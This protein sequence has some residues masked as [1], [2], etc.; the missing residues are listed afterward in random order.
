MN[1]LAAAAL[2]LAGPFVNPFRFRGFGALGG[3]HGS[4]PFPAPPRFNARGGHH[5]P[6]P[7]VHQLEIN[8]Q[9]QPWQ[10]LAAQAKRRTDKTPNLNWN[11]RRLARE[12]RN[13]ADLAVLKAG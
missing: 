10:K 7:V 1:H 9:P 12:A 3:A 2:A 11:A 5:V 4:N 13:A 8:Q 6:E